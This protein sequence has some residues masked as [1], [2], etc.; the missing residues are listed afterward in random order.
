M[1]LCERVNCAP[2]LFSKTQQDQLIVRATSANQN[3]TQRQRTWFRGC[4]RRG[5]VI[6]GAPQPSQPSGRLLL[7]LHSTKLCEARGGLTA[8]C[9]LI[10]LGARHAAV[11]QP[12][13]CVFYTSETARART[14]TF[15]FSVR[16]LPRCA[17]P[18]TRTALAGAFAAFTSA[19]ATC[20]FLLLGFSLRALPTASARGRSLTGA[21]ASYWRCVRRTT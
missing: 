11:P 5:S 18:A 14:I 7:L 6:G 17:T 1:E 10:L 19:G 20:R 2:I 12:N 21:G 16:F 4:R 9:H 3:T 15:L 13:V 8:Q